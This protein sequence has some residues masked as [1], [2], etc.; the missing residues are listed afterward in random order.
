MYFYCIFVFVRGIFFFK[1]ANEPNNNV[2]EGLTI[3]IKDTIFI[4]QR[5]FIAIV[6][7]VV[8]VVVFRVCLPRIQIIWIG[9]FWLFL[10]FHLI[11]IIVTIS[12]IIVLA[13]GHL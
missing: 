9:L 6:V 4:W 10:F 1:N 12:I 3:K 11:A 2:N 7:A 5:W 8:V 13:V